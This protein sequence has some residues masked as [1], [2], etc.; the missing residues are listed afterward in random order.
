MPFLKFA[1]LLICY[2]HYVLVNVFI[3]NMKQLLLC[4]SFKFLIHFSL[5]CSPPD[6]SRFDSSGNLSPVSSQLSSELEEHKESGELRPRLKSQPSTWEEQEEPEED[7]EQELHLQPE[8][9]PSKEL[10]D[11]S[12]ILPQPVVEAHDKRT[13]EKIW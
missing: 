8:P 9:T 7:F 5:P 1:F 13:Q 10:T 11:S 6:S 4:C 2:N 3:L 12:V